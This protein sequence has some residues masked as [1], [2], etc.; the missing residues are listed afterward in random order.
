MKPPC[1][2]RPSSVR[3][4]ATGFPPILSSAT[5]AAHPFPGPAGI[6]ARANPGRPCGRQERLPP[7][8]LM[9]RSSPLNRSSSVPRKGTC[10]CLRA[11]VEPRVKHPYS[12]D[13]E[14]EPEPVSRPSR[15]AGKDP[16]YSPSPPMLSRTV[17]VITGDRAMHHPRQ[18]PP[19]PQ[20][21]A[22][23]TDDPHRGSCGGCY[24]ACCSGCHVR[25]ADA[26]RRVDSTLRLV[27]REYRSHADT[28]SSSAETATLS[29]RPRP[30]QFPQKVYTS[31][32]TT[33]EASREATG[34]R[35]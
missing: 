33:W 24:P 11:P 34:Y 29:S 15:R 2:V 14:E 28:T 27:N 30:F 26:D 6:N 35:I 13:D 22:G 3:N 18:D 32:S 20:F 25:P 9:R 7:V 8:P 4:A 21:Y 12:W 16:G 1:L 10:R 23:Q 17:P 5:V 31:I 19:G